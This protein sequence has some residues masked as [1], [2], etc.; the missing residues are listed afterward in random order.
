MID[1]LCFS[2][3]FRGKLIA[4]GKHISAHTSRSLF[5]E[6]FA[7]LNLGL[8][9]VLLEEDGACRV[10]EMFQAQSESSTKIVREPKLLIRRA[11]QV[12]Q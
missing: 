11:S 2:D 10:Q 9:E 7:Q 12:N 5:Q 8:C 1:K 4:S 6:A 3:K